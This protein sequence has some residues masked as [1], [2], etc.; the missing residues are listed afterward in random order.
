MRIIV[1]RAQACC[2]MTNYYEWVTVEQVACILWKAKTGDTGGIPRQQDLNRK[3]K[4]KIGRNNKDVPIL[5]TRM[6]S[7]RNVYCNIIIYTSDVTRWANAIKKVYEKTHKH[8]IGPLQ[9]GYQLQIYKTDSTDRFLSVGV[10]TNSM[11]LM[12]Q[13]GQRGENDLLKFLRSY[14]DMLI[15]TNSESDSDSD[16]EKNESDSDP[17]SEKSDDCTDERLLNCTDDTCTCS[18]KTL[19][20]NCTD[21]ILLQ[22]SGNKDSCTCSDTT[23]LE[24]CT[25]EIL[26]QQSGNKDSGSDTSSTTTDKETQAN[27]RPELNIHR[28]KEL[29]NTGTQSSML[30]HNELL[31]YL[32]HQLKQVP[33]DSLIKLCVDFYS[34]ED[35]LQA[36]RILFDKHNRQPNQWAGIK[37]STHEMISV[38]LEEDPENSPSYV[39]I[40]LSNL[41]PVGNRDITTAQ[42]LS[43]IKELRAS[44][45]LL[46]TGHKNLMELVGQQAGPQ[47]VMPSKASEELCN[48]T[49]QRDQV[50]REEAGPEKEDINTTKQPTPSAPRQETTETSKS[51][52]LPTPEN[53]NERGSPNTENKEPPKPRESTKSQAKNAKEVVVFG[54]NK[55]RLPLSTPSTHNSPHNRTC[56][57]LF[58]TRLHAKTKEAEL[59]KYIWLNSGYNIKAEQLQTRYNTYSSFF[60]RADKKLRDALMDP[61][62]WPPKSMVKYFF[63]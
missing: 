16:S 2:N 44:V 40:D 20:E 26:L 46:T 27:T 11:K 32:K 60:I 6:E 63:N 3:E 12:I 51:P 22:Q 9:G 8:S 50:K 4:E 10:F 21:E 54:K 25:D 30:V 58:V 23:L 38:M 59:E 53:G 47:V 34:K 19:L 45:A 36:R 39:A 55:R 31:C 43:E 18:D 37:G 62:I 57:G 7:G 49:D 29:M 42:L 1:K 28:E 41:P 24:N 48:G 61:D 52:L 33:V 17:D 35:I 14:Q 5:D 15:L 13:P 56:T